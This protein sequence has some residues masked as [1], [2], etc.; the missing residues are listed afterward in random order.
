MERFER[1][2]IEVSLR[3]TNGVQRKAADL[4]GIKATTLHE[5][6]KRLKIGPPDGASGT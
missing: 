1:E 2:I 5:K 4:L 3:R 6:I